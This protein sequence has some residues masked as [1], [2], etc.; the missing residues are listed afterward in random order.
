MVQINDG[1]KKQLPTSQNGTH[2]EHSHVIII[3]MLGNLGTHVI[4]I[5]NF[6]CTSLPR[7]SVGKLT[8]KVASYASCQED[9]LSSLE[10]C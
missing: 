9:S 7:K 6:F 8:R 2:T 4:T 1:L 3:W 10:A 5:C